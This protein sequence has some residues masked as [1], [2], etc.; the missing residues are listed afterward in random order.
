[1]CGIFV[2]LTHLSNLEDCDRKV[3]QGLILQSYRG[4]DNLSKIAYAID[5]SHVLILGHNR[6]SI[7][8]LS[9]TSNQPIESADTNYSLVFDGEI[10]NYKELSSTYKLSERAMQSDTWCLLELIALLGIAEA[11]KS[12]RG[13]WSFVLYSKH[14]KALYVHRDDA[15]IKPLFWHKNNQTLLISSDLGSIYK[16]FPMHINHEEVTA[17]LCGSEHSRESTYYK[18]IR[19]FAPGHLYTFNASGVLESKSRLSSYY[20]YQLPSSFNERLEVYGHLFSRS[21]ERHL[22]TDA[23]YAI[24]LSGGLDSSSIYA[25]IKSSQ[26]I[27]SDSITVQ[28]MGEEYIETDIINQ[29]CDSNLF[30]LSPSSSDFWNDFEDW[31]RLYHSPLPSSSVYAQFC[32]SRK[33]KELSHKII[34]SG[35]GADEV[36]AGYRY[37]TASKTFIHRYLKT[38]FKRSARSN[39]YMDLLS[40]PVRT[41]Y[42]YRLYQQSYS[43]NLQHSTLRSF[44]SR[45]LPKLLYQEDISAMA[46]SI[47][48]RVPFLD[49]DLVSF[50]RSLPDTDL[51]CSGFT[52]YIHRRF[53][54]NLLP[55]RITSDRSKRGFPTPEAKWIYDNRD[56]VMERIYD[57]LDPLEP[58]F[59]IKTL[60]NFMTTSSFTEGSNYKSYL[61]KV[62][63]LATWLTQ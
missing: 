36:L 41:Q 2:A 62:F 15:G 46:N 47:E 32:V 63:S 55:V 11:V 53:F 44:D 1:M 19:R 9:D 17:F 51:R 58:Y 35:Q 25:G 42:I 30:I 37:H 29:F 61:W 54:E 4:P 24:A 13:M 7:I 33:A 48:N 8:D 40:E 50:V 56:Y 49:Q 26:N 27:L 20:E 12:L 38:S 21:L 34:I 14:E 28:F 18:G 59:N 31:H 5:S 45:S 22:V 3:Q 16:L 52:K 39:L 23:S 57:A 6:L 10:Y 60:R 43:Y